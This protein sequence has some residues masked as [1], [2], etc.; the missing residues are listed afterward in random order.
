[1]MTSIGETR[2]I[3]RGSNRLGVGPARPCALPDCDAEVAMTGKHGDTLGVVHLNDAD[4]RELIEALGGR[5]E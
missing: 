4:R 5:H 1:M 2:E 3:G